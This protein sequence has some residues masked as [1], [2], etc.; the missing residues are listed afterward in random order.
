MTKNASQIFFNKEFCSYQDLLDAIASLGDPPNGHKRVF[1]GQTK[2]AEGSKML[3]SGFRGK[4]NSNQAL[5][6]LYSLMLATEIRQTAEKQ[7]LQI[8]QEM[9]RFGIQAI[10]QHYGPYSKFLDV[11]HSVEVALWFA[12]HNAKKLRGR[13]LIDKQ[14]SNVAKNEYEFERAEWYIYSLWK[15]SCGYLFVFD[16]PEWTNSDIFSVPQH[17]ELIDLLKLTIPD[18]LKQ[19]KRMQVQQACLIKGDSKVNGG[20]LS[21][22]LVCH[23]IQVKWPMEGA[24]LL[25]CRTEEIFPCPGED[26]WYKRLLSLPF[27]DHVDPDIKQIIT[28]RPI[29]VNV[30]RPDDIWKLGDITRCFTTV[31]PTLEAYPDLE[32]FKETYEP[33]LSWLFAEKR[34]EMTTLQLSEATKI[35]LE[36]PVIA[37]DLLTSLGG[38]NHEVLLG[39][40]SPHIDTYDLETGHKLNSISTSN[41]FVE[42]SPLEHTHWHDHPK[43]WGKRKELPTSLWLVRHGFRFFVL[44]FYQAGNKTNLEIARFLY[45]FE[46]VEKRFYLCFPTEGKKG[47]ACGVA[48]SDYAFF[49]TLKIL[50]ELSSTRKVNFVGM[51]PRKDNRW[52]IA[53]KIQNGES[54]RLMRIRSHNREWYVLRDIERNQPYMQYPV[55]T[56][57]GQPPEHQGKLNVPRPTT[58]VKIKPVFD[59]VFKSKRPWPELDLPSIRRHSN[60]TAIYTYRLLRSLRSL[61]Q[62]TMAHWSRVIQI[63]LRYLPRK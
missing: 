34:D 14:F 31:R 51:F 45:E 52:N 38:Y 49:A 10:V 3:P 54:L 32:N 12:L 6:G 16:V 57:P 18:V 22:F 44:F 26:P 48:W 21:D 53:I 1:R 11:T 9:L 24:R 28:D 61:V 19:S 27:V 2:T 15:E 8:D 41:L 59:I 37:T 7:E 62:T 5:F 30:Y 29:R 60:E 39:G 55:L 42:F 4:L 43:A 23:P 58:K 46:P 47:E 56:F 63:L 50:S 36:G 33:D 35:M 13:E 25:N 17:G 40:M 20:D